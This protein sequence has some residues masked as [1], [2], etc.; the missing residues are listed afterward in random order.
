MAGVVAAS[1]PTS[2]LPGRRRHTA[3]CAKSLI[4]GQLFPGHLRKLQTIRTGAGSSAT[5]A[6]SELS[7]ADAFGP[8]ASLL[9]AA[10]AAL[11]LKQRGWTTI[12]DLVSQEECAEY[13]ESVWHWLESLGTGI[14]RSASFIQPSPDCQN[15]GCNAA[16]VRPLFVK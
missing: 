15:F 12:D 4:V 3:R 5:P 2:T 13:V 9:V 8:R 16:C 14:S 7:H 11:Q 10:K 1:V 6:S